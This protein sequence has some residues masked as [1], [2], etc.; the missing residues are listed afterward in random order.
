MAASDSAVQFLTNIL[1]YE[2]LEGGTEGDA[3]KARITPILLSTVGTFRLDIKDQPLKSFFAEKIEWARAVAAQKHIHVD[4]TDASVK[5]RRR[6][7]HQLVDSMEQGLQPGNSME[8]G[9]VP[10]HRRDVDRE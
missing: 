5:S 7:V 1:D 9:K 4:F 10:Y 8:T 3:L 6:E 2:D